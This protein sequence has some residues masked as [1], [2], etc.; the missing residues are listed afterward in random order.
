VCTRGWGRSRKRLNIEIM[1][2]IAAERG[3][4]CLSQSYRGIYDRLRWRC[5]R[6]HEWTT[7]AN[8]VRRGGWCPTCS[9]SGLSSL[10][11]MRNL[12]LEHG[13]RC[14][15]T[16]WIDRS[17]PLHFQCAHGHHFSRPANVVKSGVWCPK[18][19]QG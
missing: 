6:G 17:R 11:A 3:G 14:V 2:E 15:T 4:A 9:H 18:C 12:A 5:A 7:P 13:G 1:Q 10:D 8:N 16:T 19:G